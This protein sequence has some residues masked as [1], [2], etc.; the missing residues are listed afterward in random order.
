[1]PSATEERSRPNLPVAESA[2]SATTVPVYPP[3]YIPRL[4]LI[5][6]PNTGK[7]T[8]FNR[9]SGARAKTANMPGTTTSARVGRTS[10]SRPVELI[11][12]PGVYALGLDVPESRVCRS[13]LLGEGLY[14]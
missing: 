10:L 2:T 3:D 12:L 8:L 11:D 1:M 9:L 6:N 14:R 4:A 7:T 5:G 13:V